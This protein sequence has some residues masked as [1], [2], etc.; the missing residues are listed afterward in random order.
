[1]SVL[2]KHVRGPW[3]QRGLGDFTEHA[4]DKLADEDMLPLAD[5]WDI[6]LQDDGGPP[7][8]LCG[9]AWDVLLQNTHDS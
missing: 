9:E 5:P 7:G 6:C 8:L 2:Q 4:R 1:M 3:A